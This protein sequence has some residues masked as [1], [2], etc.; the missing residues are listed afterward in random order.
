MGWKN[1]IHD[2]FKEDIRRFNTPN[3]NNINRLFKLYCKTPDVMSQCAWD[4]MSAEEVT[5]ELARFIE[6]RGD[7]VHRGKRI[8]S[9]YRMVS[10]TEVRQAIVF[11]ENLIKCFENVI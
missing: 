7:V 1:I 9:D 11:F 4:K 3:A 8:V 2:K 6:I 10:D 5:K